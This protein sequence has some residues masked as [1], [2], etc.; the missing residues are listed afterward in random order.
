M[1]DQATGEVV[2]QGS[3]KDGLYQ[4]QLKSEITSQNSLPSCPAESLLSIKNPIK[5][6]PVLSQSPAKSPLALSSLSSP[7]INIESPVDLWHRRLGHPSLQIVL[8]VLEQCNQTKAM[9]STFHFCQACQMGKM[10]KLPFNKSMTEYTEP[11]QMVH[12]DLWAPCPIEPTSKV[13]G[14][15]FPLDC[16]LD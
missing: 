1:K 9:K 10:H 13:L 2:L 11:L 12:S 6:G 3:L 8:K 5:G 14:R 16:F 15:C 4:F 7:S